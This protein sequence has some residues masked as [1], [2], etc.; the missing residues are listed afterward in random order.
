MGDPVLAR[1]T[2]GAGPFDSLPS[3]GLPGGSVS[4]PEVVVVSTTASSSLGLD[5]G[6]A[7]GAVVVEDDDGSGSEED[8]GA[9]SVAQKGAVTVL[10]SNV[11][12][13]LRAS[14]RPSTVAV[15]FA[16]IEVKARIVPTKVDPTPSVADV[17]TCQ[18][19]LQAWAPLMSSTTLLV[20]VTRVDP[21]WKMKT[22]A[23]SCWASSV[24]VPV[25]ANDTGDL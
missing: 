17:P 12:A 7:A 21:V 9:P 25:T 11:T 1:G 19:T 2:P 20:A 4:G 10:V 5:A 13:P 22:A 3:H 23:G 24:S 16:V 6:V 15:V 14:S 18:K 8:V